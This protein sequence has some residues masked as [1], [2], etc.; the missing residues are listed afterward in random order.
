MPAHPHHI[1]GRP[2]PV[3][4]IAGLPRDVA[5]RLGSP[6]LSHALNRLLDVEEG[7]RD[8]SER[9][10]DLLHEHIADI[11]TDAPE[12]PRLVGLRRAVRRARTP[13]A[14]EWNGHLVRSLAP[15]TREALHD[16]RNLLDLWERRDHTVTELIEAERGRLRSELRTVADDPWFRHALSQ[17]DADVAAALR[18]WSSDPARVPRPR[19]LTRLA[20]YVTRAAVKTSP[21]STFMSLG[22]GDW[23]SCAR[24]VLLR[25]HRS[26]VEVRPEPRHAELRAWLAHAS[27]DSRVRASMRTRLNPSLTRTRD[28]WLF[29]TG[30]P[31]ERL[32]SIEAGAALDVCVKVLAEGEHVNS[33][34]LRE[35]LAGVCGVSPS[36]A[37]T[38]L[39]RLHGMGFLE[40]LPSGNVCTVAPRDLLDWPE[41]RTFMDDSVADSLESMAR[42][43]ESTGYAG[44]DAPPPEDV[45]RLPVTARLVAEAAGIQGA[46][47]ANPD[48][49]VATR[50]L[51]TLDERAWG[52]ALADLQLLRRWNSV[53]SRTVDFGSVVGRWW[54]RNLPT[55]TRIPFLV[56]QRELL[57]AGGREEV[58][59]LVRD[60]LDPATG[61]WEANGASAPEPGAALAALRE[62]ATR[63][64]TGRVG[65]DGV[66]RVPRSVLKEQV[67]RFSPHVDEVSSLGVYA[68]PLPGAPGED[69][70]LV[71]NELDV[72]YGR[73]LGRAFHLMGERTASVPP[74]A[75]YLPPADADLPVGLGAHLGTSLNDRVPSTSHEIVL[76]TEPGPPDGVDGIDLSEITVVL[77][78]ERE[79]PHL[80][81]E[82]LGRRIRPQ[83]VGMSDV[84]NFPA[85]AR[86][87]LYL[88][89]EDVN[90]LPKALLWKSWL[91]QERSPRLMVG[92]LVLRRAQWAVGSASVP[93]TQGAKGQGEDTRE[94]ARW[95]RENGI[96]D[97]CFVR[98]LPT[99]DEAREMRPRALK[100]FAKPLYVDFTNAFLVESLRRLIRSG[101]EFLL[102]EEALPHPWSDG[103]HGPDNTVEVLLEV[104]ENDRFG[105]YGG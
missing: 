21:F 86:L 47:Y 94:L 17:A 58:G 81:V 92:N 40:A 2:T 64:L 72:G 44:E 23:S 73:G 100:R 25:D 82:R 55:E 35:E 76:P 90:S 62:E 16:W 39:E 65:R 59:S 14:S 84:G 93:V 49:A 42:A 29:L 89:G 22:V 71:L 57:S 34:E 28:H 13:S 11:G 3:V 38:F 19:T 66:A 8:A 101:G 80:W 51:A 97:Q 85:S 1:H 103:E 48:T 30:A 50:P 36:E 78:P 6:G 105:F 27:K 75:S 45:T 43:L 99:E 91:H 52:P 12:R 88:F 63:T 24:P 67:E 18:S 95:R 104:A 74:L 96:P 9:A 20:R 102:F 69:V 5:T 79:G 77:D 61:I 10:S 32:V 41:A 83:H 15:D 37:E 46:D 56:F 87:L 54:R 7:L 4:R 60:L 68:Q 53:Y 31:E 70:V 33:T 98:A 26:V